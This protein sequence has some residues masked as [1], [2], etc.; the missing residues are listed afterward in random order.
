MSAPGNPTA[1]VT[2]IAPATPVTLGR[3]APSE[4]LLGKALD[5]T[6]LKRIFSY[7]WPYWKP[8]TVAGSASPVGPLP[9]LAYVR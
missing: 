6:L 3:R 5:R 1:P 8:L 4:D 9:E 7:V 2:P